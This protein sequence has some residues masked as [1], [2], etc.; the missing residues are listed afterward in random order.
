MTIKRIP[1]NDPRWMQY[2]GTRSDAGPFHHPYWMQNLE[3]SYHYSP[4]VVVVEDAS[5]QIIAGVPL[6]EVNSPLTGRRWVSLPFSDYCPPL[7]DN[8]DA[9]NSLTDGLVALSTEAGVPKIELRWEYPARPEIKTSQDF[10]Y[11]IGHFCKG[12]EQETYMQFRN[13]NRRFVR[14]TLERGVTVEIGTSL[15]F[16]KKFY[17]IHCYT[18]RKLGVPVQPWHY[19]ENLGK[20]VLEKGLGFVILAFQ[21]DECIAGNV[22][23]HYQQTL[24]VKYRASGNA[25]L[26]KL[27]PNYL[28]DWEV[29]KWGC[30]N[31]FTSFEHG[32]CDT[33]D[34]NL[35]HYKNHWEY[36]E[37]PLTYSYLGYE[38]EKEGKIYSIM[39]A[40]LQRSPIWFCRLVG[41][42]LYRHV[43]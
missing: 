18:R 41:E 7:A 21:N 36:E 15:E 3:D 14:Q 33:K 31:G 1:A 22:I 11:H 38:P 32:K 30:A 17:D 28:L 40:V 20:N 37:K 2:L 34:E 16:V 25:D 19:F 13:T 8:D 24:A 29:I 10:V 12:T 27:H 35:R 5:Q 26:T 6:A 23:L 9:L 42:V 39:H 4:F 43:G